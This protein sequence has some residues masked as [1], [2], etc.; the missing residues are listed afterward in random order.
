M[1]TDSSF[2]R[3]E[4]SSARASEGGGVTGA[5]TNAANQMYQNAPDLGVGATISS[6]MGY[7]QA[8]GQAG[9]AKRDDFDDQE[10]DRVLPPKDRRGSSNND[11]NN[12]GAPSKQETPR[13]LSERTGPSN[14]SR[15]GKSQ[16]DVG[17]ETGIPTNAGLGSTASPDQTNLKAVNKADSQ[18]KINK[19][20]IPH[21]FEPLSTS[22]G[23]ALAG[24]DRRRSSGSEQH[25]PTSPKSKGANGAGYTSPGGSRKT[26]G[27]YVPPIASDGSPIEMEKRR[28]IGE[29]VKDQIKGEIKILAGT[30][31]G[32][33]DKI[34][35]GL[36]IKHGDHHV[37]D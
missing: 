33:D 37:N 5:V 17:T 19:A 27:Q 22:G 25:H 11:I 32:K 14:E 34:I 30:V 6:Y 2:S 18:G 24:G 21:D 28:S 7:G 29:K 13:E 12:K 1:S 16:F 31:T 3:P 23:T 35:Q 9:G 36:A 8:Q 26:S 15:V 20:K 4:R 10:D